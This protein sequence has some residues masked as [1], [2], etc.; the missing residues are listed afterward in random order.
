MEKLL[1]PTLNISMRTDRAVAI[2][3]SFEGREGL[4]DSKNTNYNIKHI[5]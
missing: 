5:D 2:N 1:R 3:F 4:V